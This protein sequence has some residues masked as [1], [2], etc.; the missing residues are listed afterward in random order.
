MGNN[1][2]RERSVRVLYL[3]EVQKKAG[4]MGG[5]AELKLLA[6]QRSEQG[7]S[8][9]SADEVIPMPPEQANSHNSGALVIVDLNNNKQIQQFLE[10]GRQLVS[11]L[12]NFSRLQERFKAQEEEVE[13]WK[14]SLTYQSQELQR[15]ELEMEARQEQVQNMEAEFAQLQPQRDEIAQKKAEIQQLQEELERNRQNLDGAWV[16]LRGEQ[17]RLDTLQTQAAQANKGLS[18]EQV[19]YLHAL[20]DQV[21]AH[22][23]PIHALQ[24]SFQQVA[25]ATDGQ[26]SIL[27]HYGQQ[28]EQMSATAQQMQSALDGQMQTFHA[29]TAALLEVERSL[30]QAQ[31]ELSV[32]QSTYHLT[33]DL[34]GKLS[35]A[36]LS[37]EA[38]YQ[39]LCQMTGLTGWGGVSTKVDT[40]ALERMPLEELQTLVQD[41]ERDFAKNSRFVN[42]Q[43]EEL[44][45]QQ[46]AINE[47]QAKIQQASEYDRLRLEAE[48]ADETDRYRLL[49]ET[50]V[51]QRRNVR[52]R[53]AIANIH[54]AIL[55]RRQGITSAQQP[56]GQMDWQ[57]VIQQ[58]AT[59]MQQQ[60]KEL[61][62][63]ERQL[64]QLESLIA[65]LQDTITQKTTD[66][67]ALQQ[68]LTELETEMQ[69]RKL[70][71]ATAWGRV[72]TYQETLQG[73]RDS[74]NQTQQGVDAT[75][76]M[77]EQARMS[78]DQQHQALAQIRQ[79]LAEA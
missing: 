2:G 33:Q 41:L 71:I 60:T 3:A 67:N 43:E 70:E 23:S 46:Q 36:F 32:Q 58:F 45:Y 15:R 68:G 35:T 8:A 56:E 27:N 34:H 25:R 53:E 44:A 76:V 20:L 17:E 28:L 5:R 79:A 6:C 69:T 65:Q 30:D 74:L 63:L 4:L 66:R 14:A 7:W 38:I 78:G 16:H 73:L 31:T 62:E 26:Q 61:Q 42:D 29:R 1:F 59:Q 51:G 19:S 64:Q 24:E 10:A 49:D 11:I 55:Q 21:S 22:V 50:L 13:Q 47:L 37:Q 52:E 57:P 54:A 39:R 9:L 77:V 48:L 72:Q 12:Q 75:L 40:V 18:T